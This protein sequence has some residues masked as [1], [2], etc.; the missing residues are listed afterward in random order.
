MKYEQILQ[1]HDCYKI[2]FAFHIKNLFD[3]EE[4]NGGNGGKLKREVIY[5]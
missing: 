2:Y 4:W 3:L 1:C 5:V